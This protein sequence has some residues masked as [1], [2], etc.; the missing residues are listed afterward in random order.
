MAPVESAELDALADTLA[1]RGFELFADHTGLLARRFEE[2][3]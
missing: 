2:E 1:K 3:P